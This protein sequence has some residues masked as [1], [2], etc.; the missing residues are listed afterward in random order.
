MNVFSLNQRNI[1]SLIICSPWRSMSSQFPLS[2]W[3]RIA[4]CWWMLGLGCTKCYPKKFSPKTLQCLRVLG[5]PEFGGEVL[6]PLSS[7]ED[8]VFLPWHY[9]GAVW[10]WVFTTG[11]ARMVRPPQ[12]PLATVLTEALQPIPSTSRPPSS[13]RCHR[14]GGRALSACRNPSPREHML[15]HSL[16]VAA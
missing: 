6:P 7:L 3:C 16:L 11:S 1:L 14:G 10:G 4:L 2:S 9:S 8:S 5:K 13:S 12:V 15:A